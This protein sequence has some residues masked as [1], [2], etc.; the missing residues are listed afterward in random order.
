MVQKYALKFETDYL[1]ITHAGISETENPFDEN[2][3]DGVL[4]NRNE[5]KN[6]SKIKYTDI[7]LY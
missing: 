2:N 1:V 3:I 7:H 5:L 4:W 6:I